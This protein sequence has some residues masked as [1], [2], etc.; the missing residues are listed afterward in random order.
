[1]LLEKVLYII[2]VN[3][4]FFFYYFKCDIFIFD[5]NENIKSNVYELYKV[6]M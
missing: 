1:M 3:L 6:V 5:V 2:N 4:I